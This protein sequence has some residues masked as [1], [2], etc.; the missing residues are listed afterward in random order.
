MIYL[1]SAAAVKLVHAEAGSAALRAF[2]DERSGLEW[3]SS[4]LV[5]IETYR[6][7]ARV[8]GPADM[9]A[10]INRFHA[11]LDLVARIEIDS[12]IRILAQTVFPPAVRT[13]DAIHLATGLRLRDQGR[14]TSFVT[15]DKRLAEAASTA[16]L[17][18]DIPTS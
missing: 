15:Y 1:D 16:G 4:T 8:T 14:L 2:L 10:V 13:L 3:V 11:L 9:P 12:G 6:A 17:T 7:L 5:E 18:V